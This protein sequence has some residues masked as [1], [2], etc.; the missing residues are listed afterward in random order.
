MTQTMAGHNR[1]RFGH[2]DLG[3]MICFG[4]G[5][6]GSVFIRRKWQHVQ[7]TQPLVHTDHFFSTLRWA[8]G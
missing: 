6:G 7:P 8:C 1:Y 5:F 3:F 2:C 4:F